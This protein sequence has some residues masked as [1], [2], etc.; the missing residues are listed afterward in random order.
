[1]NIVCGW[2]ES[3]FRTAMKHFNASVHILNE[4]GLIL[5]TTVLALIC[6]LSG[7][8]RPR[9]SRLASRDGLALNFRSLAC[10]CKLFQAFLIP[11][12]LFFSPKVPSVLW[13]MR[14]CR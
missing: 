10:V 6:I 5:V 12:V 11:A 4:R 1:M 13:E 7:S 9:Y 3:H 8:R 2:K 14:L